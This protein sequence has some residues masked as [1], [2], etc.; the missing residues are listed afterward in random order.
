[1]KIDNSL[2]Y[3]KV[4][5]YLLEQILIKAEYNKEIKLEAERKMAEAIGVG[6]S[7]INKAISDLVAV[8]YLKRYRGI[9]VFIAP[10]EHIQALQAQVIHIALI[11]P[12]TEDYYYAEIIEEID[13][14]TFE[15]N[16]QVILKIHG[17]SDKREAEILES[18]LQLNNC[19]GVI[20]VPVLENPNIDLYNTMLNSGIGVVMV[21]R[22]HESM[23]AFPHVVFHPT[24]GSFLGVKH[25]YETGKKKLLY[26]GDD[27]KNYI[28]SM[29]LQGFQQAVLNNPDIIGTHLFFGDIQF[30]GSFSQLLRVQQIDGIVVYND[31]IAL[32]IMSILI[33][34]G[35][36]I[37]EQIGIVGHD[38]SNLCKILYKQLTS[39]DFPKKRLA[40][41]AVELLTNTM[42]GLAVTKEHVLPVTLKIRESTLS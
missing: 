9:G 38:N 41:L 13:R 4:K 36:S 33:E 37:P 27:Q 17:G 8:G 1:M 23:S 40:K 10:K 42:N 24:Q 16:I 20:T 22:I 14:A 12:N 34:E 30:R 39:V 18:I 25:L 3:E 31:F 32:K 6:R 21:N 11:L 5:A 7:S 26:V 35:Y 2:V 29:R 15:L 19:Q 28:D